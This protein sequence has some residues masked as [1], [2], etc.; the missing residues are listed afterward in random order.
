MTIA[1]KAKVTGLIL[2]ASLGLFGAG[3]IA[4]SQLGGLFEFFLGEKLQQ[5]FTTE[6]QTTHRDPLP[7]GG[8]GPETLDWGLVTTYDVRLS[9]DEQFIEVAVTARGKTQ[10][11]LFAARVVFANDDDGDGVLGSKESNQIMDVASFDNGKVGFEFTPPGRERRDGEPVP[12]ELPPEAVKNPPPP[13][14]PAG[15]LP[16]ARL[17]GRIPVTASKARFEAVTRDLGIFKDEISLPNG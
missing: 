14:A 13:S 16:V 9:A 2:G 1:R 11:S 5:T 3:A 4:R 12:A 6:S 15:S 10:S 17:S 8:F 7:G